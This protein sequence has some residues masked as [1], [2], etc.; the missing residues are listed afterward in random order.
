MMV[1]KN[2]RE[3]EVPRFD[4]QWLNNVFRE[5]NLGWKFPRPIKPVSPLVYMYS[6]NYIISQEEKTHGAAN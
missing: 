4:D 1:N 6:T 2:H 3:K 5:N